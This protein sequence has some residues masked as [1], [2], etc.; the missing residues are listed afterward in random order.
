MDHNEIACNPAC[1]RFQRMW[2]VNITL[3]LKFLFFFC[4]QS[5]YKIIL[6]IFYRIKMWR[7]YYFISNYL[8]S[9]KRKKKFRKS[10]LYHSL[11]TVNLYYVNTKMTQW[12][13]YSD[14]GVFNRILVL[15]CPTCQ[16]IVP[17]TLRSIHSSGRE[18]GNEHITI[19]VVI[20]WFGGE[21][22]CLN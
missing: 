9:Q 11:R 8:S 18:W 20:I 14:S 22:K 12:H 7:K 6:S 21:R 19:Q 10:Q 4:C 2:A 16:E 15:S 3:L 17:Q 5:E 13:M 1:F